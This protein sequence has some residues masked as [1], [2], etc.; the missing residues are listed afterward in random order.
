MN[1]ISQGECV[2]QNQKSTDKGNKIL[3]PFERLQP[4]SIL[5]LPEADT[6]MTDAT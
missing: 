5:Y 6:D 4:L 3:R 2:D 1:R